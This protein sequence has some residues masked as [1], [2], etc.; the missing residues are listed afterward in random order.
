MNR[1]HC[2][3]LLSASSPAAIP[4]ATTAKPYPDARRFRTSRGPMFDGFGTTLLNTNG[5][6]HL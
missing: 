1:H 3:T 5:L 4:T 2:G 6:P